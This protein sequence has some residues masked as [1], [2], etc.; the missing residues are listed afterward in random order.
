MPRF[1]LDE[2]MPRPLEAALRNEGHD[3]VAVQDVGLRGQPDTAVIAYATVEGRVL[4][5]RDVEFGNLRIYPLGSH[6]GV[7]LMRYPNKTTIDEVIQL[8][9]AALRLLTEDDLIGNLVVLDP[10]RLR[11][12]RKP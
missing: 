8:I 9:T 6:A 3:A 7:V 1:L 2:N 4:V 12:R 10:Q 5:T 11:I